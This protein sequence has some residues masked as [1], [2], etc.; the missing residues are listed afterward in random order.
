MANT[1][2]SGEQYS[3]TVVAG[4]VRYGS[5]F[6]NIEHAL[7]AAPGE[8]IKDPMTG[9]LYTKRAI[10]GKLISFAHKSRTM[11]EFLQEFNLQFQSS[12][13]FRY[14][15]APGAYL[16]GTWFDVNTMITKKLGSVVNFYADSLEF[17]SMDSNMG[18]VFQFQVSPDT[19]GVFI[20]AT[21]RHGDKNA[22]AYLTGKFSLEE[23]INFGGT[24][25]T[26]TEWL[27]LHLDYKSA[28]VYDTWRNLPGWSGSNMLMET[29]ITTTGLDAS[30]RPITVTV[31]QTYALHLGEAGHISFPEGYA[32]NI[33]TVNSITVRVDKIHMPKIQYEYFLMTTNTMSTIGV[34]SPLA[35]LLEADLIGAMSVVECYYF[36]TS[37]AQLPSG[38]NRIIHQMVDSIFFREAI[39]KLLTAS[40]TRSA[41][42]GA[43]KPTSWGLDSIWLEETR[44]VLPGNTV[45]PTGSGN[46]FKTLEK[47]LYNPSGDVDVYF[48]TK[49]TDRNN[50]YILIR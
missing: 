50:S 20:K 37:A 3:G 44:E 31:N 9:E 1:E 36:I 26:F 49:N 24:S 17:P 7:K 11:Y 6:L 19:N 23:S 10:D 40:G 29:T 12:I 22:L 25:K 46:D 28:A 15:D 45:I 48:T 30:S 39:E 8:I 16:I 42:T 27:Q 33:E 2:Y 18:N 34:A 13:N 35:E 47:E 43:F 41:Q 32:E 38:D 5:T 21:P 14:P 4:D